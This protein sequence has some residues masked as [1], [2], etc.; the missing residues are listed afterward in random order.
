MN[1]VPRT[2]AAAR[3][4]H[5]SLG[6]ALTLL[7]LALALAASLARAEGT[8]VSIPTPVGTISA[9]SKGAPVAVSGI[10]EFP[11]AVRTEGDPDGDG[12]QA[13][14]KL[15]VISMKMQALRYRTS[16]SMSSVLSFYRE[17]LGKL[18]SLK[19][20]DEGPHTEFGDFRWTP[21]PGQ[22]SI[23]AEADHHAYIVAM[24]PEGSG[25]QFALMSIRFEE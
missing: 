2:L 24:K 14:L 13:T 23:A 10:P 19:E 9:K 25:C 4:S 18:G 20:S 11:G 21:T 6:F 16:A 12:A 3:L 5:R 8:K 17:K 7:A 1:A 22:H 15:P